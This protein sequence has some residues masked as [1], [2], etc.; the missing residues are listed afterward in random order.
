LTRTGK[1]TRLRT[2]DQVKEARAQALEMHSIEMEKA[3]IFSQPTQRT[4]T[5]GKLERTTKGIR[6]FL[7]TNVKDYASLNSATWASGGKVFMDEYLELLFRYG[8]SEKLCLCGSGLLLGI[9]RMV[10][11]DATMTITPGIT[12]Y[13]IKVVTLVSCFGELHFK[14]HPL[15]TLLAPLRHSG[16]IVDAKYLNYRYID[17]TKYLPNRQANDLDGE[18]SEFLTE[19]GLELHFEKAHGWL[20]NIGVDGTVSP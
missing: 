4:G 15:F 3:F 18:K 1:A 20:D 9:Q 8:S 10:D 19:A 12:S 6:N 7:S 14:M 2:G 11:A 16:L 5:N 17:D 13:G